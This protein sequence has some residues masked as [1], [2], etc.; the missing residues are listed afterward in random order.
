MAHARSEPP[1]P[2]RLFMIELR[3]SHW[4]RSLAWYRDLIGLRVV[5]RQPEDGF[6][7]LDGGGVRLALKRRAPGEVVTRNLEDGPMLIFEVA[8]A[9]AELAR[10]TAAGS[11]VLKPLATNLEG[12]RRAVVADPDGHPVTLFDFQPDPT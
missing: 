11:P 12:Y 5:L 3:S 10:L 2:A 6:A 7:M 8:D 1:P 9:A 4:E